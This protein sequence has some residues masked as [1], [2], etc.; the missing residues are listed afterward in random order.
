MILPILRPRHLLG[1]ALLA[2]TLLAGAC[3]N[4]PIL[5]PPV[6]TGPVG[7]AVGSPSAAQ[8]L[9]RA[10]YSNAI[11]DIFGADVVVPSALEPD[12]AVDGLDAVGASESTVSSRGIEQYE[13]AAFAIGNQIANDPKL[14]ARLVGCAPTSVDDAACART[15][16]AAVGPK[17]Y[18]RP[19]TEPEIASVVTVITSAGKALSSF[20]KGIAYGVARMLQSPH[21]L[22]RVS[23]GEADPENPGKRRHTAYEL[24]TR[25]SFFLWNSVP[26]DALYDLAKSGAI[27]QYDRLASEVERML[28]SPKAHEG[29]RTFVADWLRLAELDNL[30][31]DSKLF[32][33]Y[34]ADLGPNAREETLRVFES[35]VFDDDADIRDFL[36]TRRTFVTPKLAAMYQVFAPLASG[37]ARINLPADGQRRGYLGHLSFLAQNAHPTSSSATLRGKFVREKLLCSPIPVP[38]VNLNTGFPEANAQARTLRERAVIHFAEPGC[39]GCHKLMDPIGFGLETYDGIGRTRVKENGAPIDTRGDLDGTAFD[40]PASLAQAVHDHPALPKCITRNVYRYAFGS[41]V[42]TFEEPTMAALLERFK[43]SRYRMKA[44]L[45]AVATSPAFRAHGDA[46]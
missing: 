16:V 37:Y 2:S 30:T 19:I 13:S 41:E 9:T 7:P 28:A 22:Y 1:A 44:L 39:A 45:T 14:R 23:F 33:T 4:D 11:R 6:P 8:R 24:A 31:K 18:R 12:V 42:V 27:F 5:D 29:V 21:F 40:G 17:V 36:T 35:L 26:D 38:P 34:T 43:A 25:L 46:K 15:F 10:Q 32:T 20:E 3:D